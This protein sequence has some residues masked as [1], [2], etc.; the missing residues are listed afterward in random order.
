M[1]HVMVSRV[2]LQVCSL[3]LVESQLQA[4]LAATRAR[5]DVATLRAQRLAAALDAAAAKLATPAPAQKQH[6]AHGGGSDGCEQA[7]PL[8]VQVARLTA[9]LAAQGQALFEAQDQLLAAQQ[10]R[11]T[12]AAAVLHAA[13]AA[14]VRL[15]NLLLMRRSVL[16]CCPA[17]SWRRASWRRSWRTLQQ[18]R[19]QRQQV[20]Q[21]RWRR[22][23]RRWVLQ[24]RRARPRWSGSC[25]CA[26][27]AAW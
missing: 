19:R 5:S 21:R 25:R 3:K 15:L 6:Q 10:V 9:K 23:G 4:S 27:A 17:G 13:L 24:R 1:S 12:R 14:L 22:S 18:P 16:S 7:E 8:A 2:L 20:R 11:G 26:D